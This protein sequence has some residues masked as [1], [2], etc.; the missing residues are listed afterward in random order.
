MEKNKRNNFNARAEKDVDLNKKVE[1]QIHLDT[2]EK[3][4][5]IAKLNELR[6]E[7]MEAIDDVVESK[8]EAI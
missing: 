4:E 8:G 6:A 1:S 7:T 3:M 5:K 2:K